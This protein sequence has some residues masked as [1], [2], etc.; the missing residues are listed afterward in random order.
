MSHER[1]RRE[2]LQQSA[3]S[4]AGLWAITR[5]APAATRSP[6]EKLSVAVIGVSGQGGAYLAQLSGLAR[7][8]GPNFSNLDRLSR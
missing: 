3:L 4:A 6:N 5:D 2:F 8:S 7:C 1:T